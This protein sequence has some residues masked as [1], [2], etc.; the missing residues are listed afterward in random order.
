VFV[1]KH[2]VFLKKEFLAKNVSERTVQLNEISESSATI[3]MDK[4]LEVIP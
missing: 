4:E 2:G 1:A 3:D